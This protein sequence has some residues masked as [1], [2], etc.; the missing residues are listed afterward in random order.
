MS[1]A[2]ARQSFYPHRNEPIWSR[3]EKT[4]ARIVFDAA[5]K[6]ERHD[7]MQGA[8]RRANQISG[9]DDLWDLMRYLSQRRRKNIDCKYG[10]R[11][12][13]LTR[14]FERPLSEGR[15]TADEL[16]GLQEEKVNPIRYCAKV[17][18]RLTRIFER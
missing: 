16:H 9:P 6:R 14:G 18:P 10:F 8:R 12:L 13:R 7:V 5:L 17:Y 3:A 4:I 11:S 15:V 1:G 2:S